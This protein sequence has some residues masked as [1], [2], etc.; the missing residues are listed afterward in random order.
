MPKAKWER[1]TG[2]LPPG[3]VLRHHAM[4]AGCHLEASLVM[5]GYGG[6]QLRLNGQ[7]IG[8]PLVD[9]TLAEGRRR[10]HA[11][12]KQHGRPRQMTLAI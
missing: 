12:L 10:Y 9:C 7:N 2:S 4:V 11:M 3:T 5:N 1:D 6:L 8:A